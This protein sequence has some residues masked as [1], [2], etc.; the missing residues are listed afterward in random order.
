MPEQ[1]HPAAKAG[2][3]VRAAGLGIKAAL[4][5][6]EPADAP[7]EAPAPAAAAPAAAVAPDTAPPAAAGPPREQEHPAATA[8]RIVRAAGLGVKAALE[9][10]A[11]PATAA[12][13]PPPPP[14]TAAAPPPRPAPA[15]AP[16]VPPPAVPTHTFAGRLMFG[17]FVASLIAFLVVVLRVEMLFSG[18]PKTVLQLVLAV[19]LLAVALMLLGNWQRANQRIVQRLANRVW[20]P[21]GAMNR[22]ER[23]F[24]GAVRDGLK[25]LGIAFLALGVWELLAATVGY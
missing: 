20:G 7:A 11:T 22:R 18:T 23:F 16:A 1:E 14:P 5:K 19:I 6:P 2:R 24:A 10:P 25:L 3:F 8:G 12:P 21:R 15:P 4:E 9:T 13:P 17:A